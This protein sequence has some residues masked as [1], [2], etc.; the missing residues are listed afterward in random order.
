MP[1][2]P[3]WIVLVLATLA[4]LVW[5][6]LRLWRSAKALLAEVERAGA[7]LDALDADSAD[8]AVAPIESEL[9]ASPERR[10][11]LR[12]SR[13]AVRAA[14]RARRR[15]RFERAYATWQTITGP[16]TTPSS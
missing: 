2:W 14:R 5:L 16:P 6:G 7:V 3:I 1:W 11:E 10:A 12:A 9:F 8:H 13:S 15:D 4:L